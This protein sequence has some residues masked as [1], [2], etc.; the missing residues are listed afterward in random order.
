MLSTTPWG[1]EV[2]FYCREIA[3]LTQR[4]MDILLR[5]LKNTLQILDILFC[6]FFSPSLIFY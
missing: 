4:L 3:F 6:R 1:D 2:T 5:T